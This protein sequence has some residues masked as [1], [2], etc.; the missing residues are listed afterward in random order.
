MNGDPNALYRNEGDGRFSD[1]APELG[2]DI[3]ARYD[4]CAFGDFDLVM[5][6][7]MGSE[8]KGRS[9]QVRVVDAAGHATR[10]GAKVRVYAAGTRTL[11]GTRIL[12]TGSGYDSQIVLP[13]HF[14]LGGDGPVDVEVVFPGGG[15]RDVTEVKNVDPAAHVG[16]PVTVVLAG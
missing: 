3:D 10:A 1:L 5:R 15:S 16:R 14:G 2:L 4:A 6:N 13:A 9:I 12:D 8:L 11:L 7:L